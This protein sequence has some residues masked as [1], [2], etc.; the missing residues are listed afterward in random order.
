M[1]ARRDEF[2]TSGL[3]AGDAGRKLGARDVLH[4]GVARNVAGVLHNL[5]LSI[6][7]ELLDGGIGGMGANDKDRAGNGGNSESPGRPR[8]IHGSQCKSV[9]GE[10]AAYSEAWLHFRGTLHERP[11]R[12]FIWARARC[13]SCA[14]IL[15]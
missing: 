5:R 2:L 3:A 8:E 15:M 9:S 14:L 10:C 13:T 11:Q 7:E 6:A 12:Y 4:A 1:A